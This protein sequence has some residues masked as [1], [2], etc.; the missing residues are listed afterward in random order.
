MNT[1][2]THNSLG[3]DSHDKVKEVTQEIMQ[4]APE[5]AK[6]HC[7]KTGDEES[8]LL[9]MQMQDSSEKDLSLCSP[10]DLATLEEQLSKISE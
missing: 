1:H 4:L 9:F 3:H 8:Q 7:N 10:V 2:V 6:D 5:K